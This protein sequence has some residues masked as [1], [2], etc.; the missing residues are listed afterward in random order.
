M[1]KSFDQGPLVTTRQR[2][3]EAA[4]AEIAEHG[5]GGVRTRRVSQRA[6]VNNALVHYHFRSIDNL[7]LEAAAAA[8]GR[9]AE[10]FGPGAIDA[11]APLGD[12]LADMAVRIESAH[13][14]DPIWQVLMEVF[15]QA[16]RDPR[17]GE[18]ANGL[19]QAYRGLTAELVT[20]AV[21]R[22][23]L[24]AGV[25]VSGVATALVAMLDGLG[26]HA[27]ADRHLDIAGAGEAMAALFRFVAATPTP[28]RKAET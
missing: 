26:L 17:L 9:L 28:E 16:P 5:W 14:D 21:D 19:L 24:P 25:D 27:Y 1:P 22:G 12:V 20:R 23:E 13:L 7:R 8:F 11:E 3:I 10:E 6:G 4:L 18:M 15:L 2:I